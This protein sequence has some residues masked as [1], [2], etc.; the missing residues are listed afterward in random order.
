MVASVTLKRFDRPSQKELPVGSAGMAS[1]PERQTS[2]VSDTKTD[3]GPVPV[4]PSVEQEKTLELQEDLERKQRKLAAILLSLS[5]ELNEAKNSVATR[6]GEV[7]ADS[8]LAILPTLL[9]SGFAHEFSCAVVQ[10]A[11]VIEQ[12][13]ITLKVHPNDHE[14]MVEALQAHAPPHPVRV[15]KDGSMASGSIQLSWPDGG[16]EIDKVTLLNHAKGLL[17]TR[18]ASLVSGKNQN[19]H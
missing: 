5:T 8:T 14:L 7:I 11:S 4:Q 3:L 9:D 17:E 10:I 6:I 19:E 2:M 15:E 18:I 12:D 13:Q 16:A 1:S